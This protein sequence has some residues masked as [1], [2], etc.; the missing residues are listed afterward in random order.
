VSIL[1][2]RLEDVGYAAASGERLIEG[3]IV[4]LA[5]GPRTVVLGPNGAGK[6]LLLQL[7]HGL[8]RQT[9]GRI[10]SDAYL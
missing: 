2:L 6:S 4:E 7:C 9:A 10:I 3:V 1:P 5:A 8:I